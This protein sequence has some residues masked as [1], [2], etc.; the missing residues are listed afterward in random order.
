MTRVV[1][2]SQGCQEATELIFQSQPTGSVRIEVKSECGDLLAALN[3][4]TFEVDAQRELFVW[5]GSQLTAI[6]ERLPHRAYPFLFAALKGLQ[7]EE[8]L[9]PA[10]DITLHISKT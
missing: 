6:A 3:T 4:L 5:E 1:F 10:Q 2:Y 7:V 8:N 9:A